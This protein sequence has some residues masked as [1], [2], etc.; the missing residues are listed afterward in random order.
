MQ[1]DM[2][3]SISAINEHFPAR[4]VMEDMHISAI[5]SSVAMGDWKIG[6]E[7]L[8]HVSCKKGVQLSTCTM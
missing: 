3:T 2:Y 1:R 7:D 4:N 8:L 5:A 6:S